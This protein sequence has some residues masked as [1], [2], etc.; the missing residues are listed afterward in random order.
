MATIP[1]TQ[2]K[3]AL[4][5]DED[6]ERVNQVKWRY[7]KGAAQ[8]QT[9]RPER[10]VLLMH[11]FVMHA[12]DGIEVDHVNGN[13]LDNRKSN[14]RIATHRQNMANQKTRTNN[15]SGYKGVSF[16]RKNKKWVSQISTGSE[17]FYL[18]VFDTPLEAAIAYDKRASELFGKFARLNFRTK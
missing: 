12:P 3:F 6:F 4:I 13:A 8:S 16:H 11:R 5:D 1:L 17:H 18:G 15:R 7:C 2:G 10:K 9:A 14:L